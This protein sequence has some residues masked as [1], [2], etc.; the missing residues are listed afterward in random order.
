METLLPLMFVFIVIVI[1]MIFIRAKSGSRFEVK[2]SDISVALIPIAMWLLLTGKITG[3]EFGGLKI[4]TVFAD[5][6]KAII[7]EQVVELPIKKLEIGMK[8]SVSDI[9]NL[10]RQQ[11]EVL[12]FQ[13]GYGGYWGEAI[14]KYLGDLVVYPFF[15]YVEINQPNG[16]FFGL[17]DARG[18][19]SIFS[20]HQSDDDP[21]FQN[22]NPQ[23]SAEDFANWLNDSRED[24]IVKL[25]GFIGYHSA[26]NKDTDK[27]TA[28]EQMEKLNVETLPV[29]D[30]EDRFVGIVE[31]SRLAS[32]LIIEVANKLR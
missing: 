25:P 1:L 4:E 23:Y 6:S 2:N 9:P 22:S 28:L 20:A 21:F 29:I 7:S 3:L 5:A 19:S 16:K 31:R 24:Q 26:V 11:T 18:L 13:L 17:I 32:S 12:S 15:K 8:G 30:E 14:K 10:I 27:Q